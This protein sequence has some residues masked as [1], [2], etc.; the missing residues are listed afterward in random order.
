MP[1]IAANNT[2]A[3]EVVNGELSATDLRDPADNTRYKDTYQ[4]TNVTAGQRIQ[5]KL[6]STAFDTVLQLVNAQTGAVIQENDDVN[7]DTTNSQITFT[8]QAG[9]EYLLRATS[10]GA[11][12]TGSYALTVVRPNAVTSTPPPTA[13]QLVNQ[14]QSAELKTEVTTRIADN[15][16]DRNDAIAILRAGGTSGGGVDA[17]ELDDLK[18]L[19]NNSTQLNMPDAVR[20]FINRIVKDSTANTNTAQ[21]ESQIGR[22]FL[23]TEAPT[24]IFNQ[25]ARTDTGEAA[26]DFQLGYATLQGPLFGSA[27]SAR[28]GHIDQG[29]LGDCAFLASLAA[30]FKPQRNDSGNQSS[31][32]VDSMI[33]DNGDNTFTVRFYD[34]T[35]LQA[36]YVTVDRRVAIEPGTGE[37]FAASADNQRDPSNPT[38]SATWVPLV[39]R[40]YAQWRQETGQTGLPGYNAIG[41]GDSITDPLTRIVG[42]RA[43]SYTFESGNTNTANFSTIQ[44]TL[45]AGGMF[46]T[47][48]TP[49]EKGDPFGKL[50][51][52][53][54]AYTVTDAY[55]Q[56][57]EQRVVVRN[58]WGIDAY[59]GY[60]QGDFNDGFIDLAYSDFTRYFSDGLGIA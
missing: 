6:E 51:V 17:I 4:L 13:N 28:I 52:P 11:N 55:I 43:Q 57:G 50:I 9:V 24:P 41:L 25:P 39:E 10:Y 27:S 44:S 37:L 35:T 18:L 58:P 45:A 5:V 14:L 8:A 32:I 26:Q 59:P 19:V 54:H 36:Q 16:L 33:T 22:W 29:Q 12:Q 2:A 20:Y 7:G 31:D 15:T 46:I 47:T 38:N 42:R 1:A 34:A 3:N 21:F 30:T 23:G 48:G 40:A 60:G 53:T 49:D 56:G